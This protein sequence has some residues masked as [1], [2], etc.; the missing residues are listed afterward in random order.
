[1]MFC[2]SATTPPELRLI[3]GSTL[4]VDCFTFEPSFRGGVLCPEAHCRV[5]I[6]AV[7]ATCVQ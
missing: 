5:E 2:L 7:Q 1:M 6:T 3:I 4:S